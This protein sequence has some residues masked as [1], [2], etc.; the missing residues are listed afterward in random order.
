MLDRIGDGF[1][2]H[3]VQGKGGRRVQHVVD[4]ADL[5]VHLKC[6]RLPK[7]AA[8]GAQCPAKPSVLKFRRSQPSDHS[9]HGI[10]GPEYLAVD[11]SVRPDA[12]LVVRLIE[13]QLGPH[14]QRHEALQHIV[15]Q[16]VRHA[17]A[18]LLHHRQDQLGARS[19]PLP[20]RDVADGAD[21]PPLPVRI[22]RAQADLDGELGAVAAHCV[23]FEAGAHRPTPRLP[24]I[25]PSVFEMRPPLAF[26]HET[27]DAK[28]R[29]RFTAPP[30]HPHRLLVHVDYEAAAIHNERGVR[31]RLEHGAVVAVLGKQIAHG[32]LE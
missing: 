15:V 10:E 28:T 27:L 22:P 24:G 18:L 3:A 5:C 11:L 6:L 1:L 14:F 19:H 4:V 17:F 9:L 12:S 13:K 7:V 23:Q 31:R 16:L 25:V 20:C 29:E 30:E 21:D 32:V 8:V 26:R 2:N